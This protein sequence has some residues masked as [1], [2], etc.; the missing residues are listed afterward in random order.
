MK[1]DLKLLI[2]KAKKRH[3][4]WTVAW[5]LL[6][7]YFLIKVQGWGYGMRV[8]GLEQEMRG[9]RSGLSSIILYKQMETTYQLCSD[10]LGQVR[11]A[12]LGGGCFLEQ[13]SRDTPP[14]VTLEELSVDPGSGLRIRGSCWVGLRDPEGPIGLFGSKLKAAGWAM[15]IREMTPDGRTPGLWRFELVSEPQGG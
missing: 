13:L 7:L 12:G 15:K 5:V 11:G 4:G 3:L 8:Q 9:L 2:E 1:I 14:S 10:S 6:A